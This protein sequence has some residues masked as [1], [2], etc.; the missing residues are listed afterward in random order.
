MITK[1]FIPEGWNEKT[2]IL[3]KN[4]IEEKTFANRRITDKIHRTFIYIR[5][6]GD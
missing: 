3:D 5:R 6:G 4:N 2:A 1:R